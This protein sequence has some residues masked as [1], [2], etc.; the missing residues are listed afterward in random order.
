MIYAEIWSW[1]VSIV[2]VGAHMVSKSENTKTKFD[3][4]SKEDINIQQ[5]F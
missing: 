3:V 5:I 2:K 1:M 4:E